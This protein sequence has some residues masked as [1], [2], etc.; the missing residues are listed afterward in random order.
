[1]RKS[2]HSAI[3]R[4][5][6]RQWPLIAAT[7]IFGVCSN[8][9]IASFAQTT[10]AFCASRLLLTKTETS[11]PAEKK[12][13]F[14]LRTT[15]ALTVSSPRASSMAASSSSRKLLS[16]ELA[17]GLSST[18]WPMESCFSRRTAMR[19]PCAKLPRLYDGQRSAREARDVLPSAREVFSYGNDAHRRPDRRRPDREDDRG[20]KSRDRRGRRHDPEGL[21]SGGRRRGR[22][23]R[24]GATGVGFDVRFEA[25]RAHACRRGEGEGR[26]AR[27][28][29]APDARAGQAARARG[30][31]SDARGREP[32]LLRG[33]RGQAAR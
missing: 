14:A 17:G 7:T 32:R 8:L 15:M 20:Q 2:Q 19:S 9:P 29:E 30:H 18:M 13:S 4:P 10:K 1:M 25:S 3:S 24:E 23:R 11:A 22:G 33:L 6:P 5:P 27:D 16:Y 12:R 26:C 21:E 28:R 31:R